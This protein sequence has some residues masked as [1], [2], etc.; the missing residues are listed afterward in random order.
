[1]LDVVKANLKKGGYTQDEIKKELNIDDL[2]L[3]LSD[4][5]FFYEVLSQNIKFYL[6]ERAYHVFGEA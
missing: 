2:S 1:M 5:P 3:V 6:Y 4:I